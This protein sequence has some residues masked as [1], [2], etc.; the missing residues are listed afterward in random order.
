MGLV[1]ALVPALEDA[2]DRLEVHLLL[3]RHRRVLA[4]IVAGRQC[5]VVGR[6]GGGVV[7]GRL[8]L[9]VCGF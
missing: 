3:R 4:F 2:R 1:A 9:V 5:V 6:G 7:A 8:N